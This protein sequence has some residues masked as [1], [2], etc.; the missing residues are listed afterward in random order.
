MDNPALID[1][2]DCYSPFDTFLCYTSSLESLINVY[3]HD[4]SFDII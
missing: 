1:V 4:L 3:N 2:M